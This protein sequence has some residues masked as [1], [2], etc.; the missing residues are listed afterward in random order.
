PHDHAEAIRQ[1]EPP[2]AAPTAPERFGGRRQLE[3]RREE[4]GPDAR[5]E[6]TA[7]RRANAARPLERIGLGHTHPHAPAR[8]SG[9]PPTAPGPT[10][11][12]WRSSHTFAGTRSVR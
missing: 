3:R 11:A 5:H 7:D 2:G 12:S 9:A 6:V 4:P 8:V 10:A 1:L